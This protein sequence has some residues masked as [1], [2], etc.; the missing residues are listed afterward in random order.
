MSEDVMTGKY[1]PKDTPRRSPEDDRRFIAMFRLRHALA[2]LF[3]GDAVSNL[4]KMPDEA[5]MAEV[6][7]LQRFADEVEGKAS[8]H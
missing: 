4:A 3:E 8:G 7:S 2:S 5:V 1:G 6:R